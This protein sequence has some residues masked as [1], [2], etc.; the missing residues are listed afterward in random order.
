M[1]TVAIVVLAILMSIGALWLAV[2]GLVV[3]SE[4]I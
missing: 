4:E 2:F 3:L 1:V